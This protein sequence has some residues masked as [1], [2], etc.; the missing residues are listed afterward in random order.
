MRFRNLGLIL[1]AGVL[2]GC[3]YRDPSIDLLHGELRWMEDQLYLLESELDETCV[4]LAR[5]KKSQTD[6]TVV[7]DPVAGMPWMPVTDPAPA[8]RGNRIFPFRK[9]GERE[10]PSA[11]ASPTSRG[12]SRLSPEDADLSSPVEVELPDAA[13]DV[14]T[15]ESPSAESTP[16]GRFE[17]PRSESSRLL[18]APAPAGDVDAPATDQQ[19]DLRPFDGPQPVPAIPNAGRPPRLGSNDPTSLSDDND[20]DVAEPNP[21]RLQSHMEPAARVAEQELS[22]ALDAHVTH[23]VV[24]ANRHLATAGKPDLSVVIEPRNADGE[25]VALPAPVSVVVLDRSQSGAAARVARWD[26]TAEETAAHV[27][28][29]GL[30]RGLHLEVT[31]P[32]AVPTGDELY[33]FARYSTIDG[34]KL[35]ARVRLEAPQSSASSGDEWTV[36]PVSSSSSNGWTVV[37]HEEPSLVDSDDEWEIVPREPAR[38]KFFPVDN[39]DAQSSGDLAGPI[40][41]QPPP[42]SA[43]RTAGTVTPPE[44]PAPRP[45]PRPQWRPDR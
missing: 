12:G 22:P 8:S 40:V 20:A 2:G 41:H 16:S 33:L 36:D 31:W 29:S 44:P 3:H 9:D 25:Y 1:I 24:T 39:N 17:A 45:V 42:L 13:T 10:T 28:V 6:C 23:I 43:L 11:Q 37:S 26:R 21:I 19:L 7:C 38:L 35:E 27:Q 4:Q 14:P 5:C 15:F 30:G 32:A 18:E 34:R